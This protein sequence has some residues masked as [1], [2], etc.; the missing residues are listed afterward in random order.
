MPRRVLPTVN[1]EYCKYKLRIRRSPI[2]SFGVYAAEQIPPGRA[3]IE[4]TGRRW[5]RIALFKRASRMSRAALRNWIYLAR[6]NRHWVL[7][8]ADGGSGAEFINH[9]CEPNLRAR[10]LRGH[11]ILFSLGIIHKGEELLWDY[12]FDK[13]GRRVPC[14]C[15][16]PNCR[17]TINVR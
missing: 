8:G 12:R 15:G 7:D 5:S 9:S 4:Y 14:R 3:V 11:V 2:H 16:S 13:H 1:S 17:G 10:R 6:I